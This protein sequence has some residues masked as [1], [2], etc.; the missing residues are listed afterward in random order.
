[1]LKLATK[2][3]PR[4]AAFENAYR[5]GFRCAE[6]W[7]GP[8]VLADW[9]AVAGL[10]RHYPNEYALHFPNRLDLTPEALE[11]TA[12]LYRALGCRC[13]VIHQG[14]MDKYQEVL[15]RLDPG[16]NLAVENSKLPPVEFA[17][18]E[19][20]N[21]GLTLD[22]EHVWKYTL[23]EAVPLPH[24]LDALAGFLQRSGARLRHVHLPGCLP[25]HR[26]HRP[27]Y[28]ARDVVFGVL[29]LLR[30]FRFEGLVVSEVSPEYQTPN[31]L[32]MDVLLFD[33]WREKHDPPP[34]TPP[35]GPDGGRLLPGDRAPGE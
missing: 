24:L 30:D 32:R 2:F 22:V 7:L 34:P 4:P 21:A 9:Q 16:L 27:M 12:A 6:L 33:T 25:G 28:G 8:E 31:D 26:E 23:G 20:R 1:M 17:R 10:A 5:A 11:H 14:M 29:S 19:G 3:A 13:L 15:R 18:W 35:P